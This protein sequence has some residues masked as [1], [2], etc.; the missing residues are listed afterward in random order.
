MKHLFPDIR[1]WPIFKLS[2]RRQEFINEINEFV[3]SLFSHYDYK[4]L[5][6]VI[7]KTIYQEKLRVKNNPWTV[8]PPNEA[9]FWAKLQKRLSEETDTS[10]S[11]NNRLILEELLRIIINRYSQ[12]IVGSFK[13]STFLFARRF[14]TL[15][16][17]AIYNP[18]SG[19]HFLTGWTSAKLLLKKLRVEGP[20]EDIRALC[21]DHIV[22]VVPTHSSNLDSILIG[23]MLDFK[24]GLPGFAYGA[25]LNLYNFGL[26]AYFMNRLGAY[27][28]DRRKKNAV[29][30]ETLKAMS[31]ISIRQGTNSLF[32]P[33]GTRSRSNQIEQKLK[34]G[35]L[36]TTVHAQ[37]DLCEEGSSTRIVIVPLVVN[38]H[39]VLEA[40]SLVNEHLR[41][42]GKEQYQRQKKNYSVFK[43]IGYWLQFFK[44][45]T[46]VVFRFG[47]PMDV[48]GNQMNAA[49]QSRHRSGHIVSLEDYFKIGEEIIKDEQRE[50]E[51]TRLLAQYIAQAY[52]ENTVVLESMMVAWSVFQLLLKQ[53]KE[54]DVFSLLKYKPEELELP[55]AI[56]EET[57]AQ[58]KALVLEKAQEGKI[59]LDE[60]LKHKSGRTLLEDGMRNLGVFHLDK[61]LY[62]ANNKIK[63]QNIRLLHFYAN[64]LDGYE[65]ENELY[66]KHIFTRNP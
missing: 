16:F 24:T 2:E 66:W 49:A 25:G 12:E 17:N 53:Y 7:T 54:P 58:L 22:I 31:Q 44:R 35:L 27:R 45:D 18:F 6:D 10:Q 55:A 32:F 23:Y 63:T 51:Y 65:F 1:D 13:I 5:H 28:V 30:L 19:K 26:A 8:D 39:F 11:A 64:R 41:A 46:E 20:V 43:R 48:F 33:G 36:G 61:V 3:Y 50:A 4:D 21:K 52:K 42:L 56:V 14:L 34:L 15:F 29:Y 59:C 62:E 57:L 38:N 9:Q 40:P 60:R 37:R 47:K